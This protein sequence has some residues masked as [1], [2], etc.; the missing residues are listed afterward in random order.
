MTAGPVPRLLLVEDSDTQALQFRRSIE[1]QGFSV[2][3]TRTAEEAL[4]QLNENLPDLLVVDYR[5]PGMNGDELVRIV[6][7]T[8]RTRTLP[9]LMLTGDAGSETERQ[10]LDSGA[11]A[12]VPKGG[13]ADL[14][15]SRMR[16]LL[17]Q[18]RPAPDRAAGEGG[19]RAAQLLLVEPA[20]TYRTLLRG[21]LA[22]E[23]YEARLAKD[24]GEALAALDSGD[25]D[26]VLL[27][28]DSGGGLDFV[29]R[30]DAR[31]TASGEGYEIVLLSE[32]DGPEAV[33]AAL[34]AGADDVVPKSSNREMLLVRIRATVRR[35]LARDDEARAAAHE[36]ERELALAHARAQAEAAEA[37]AAA[38][39][40]LADAN[41]RLQATQAQ[42]VQAAKMASLGELVAGIA[43]E[44]NN[45]LA[46]ILA[47][48]DT[49]ERSVREA[50]TLEGE[51][52]A[53][54]LAKAADR[55]ASIRTGLARIQD[56][57]VKLRR[58]SRLDEET[59]Q[60]DVPEAIEAVLTL[61]GPKLGGIAVE[62]RYEAPPTLTCSPALINQVVMNLVS[63]AADAV[64]EPDGRIVVATRCDGDAYVIEVG[65]NGRGVAAEHRE[66]V[67]EPF[68]TTKDVGAGTGL[69]LAI[70][71]G[72]V[73]AHGGGIVLGES[74]EGGALFTISIP[75]R[76]A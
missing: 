35:K 48:H 65:D 46:F 73:R 54:R 12:Y 51:A 75:I 74:P 58:F 11:N 76:P 24:E 30:L 15:V 72:I 47:H 36:R 66:R 25:V 41:A 18:R 2:A 1:P 7:Q 49:V 21:L 29:G 45:P 28:L 71:Y 42:L 70:A 64:D 63:N 43:H 50:R 40:E 9:I 27:G 6:R 22:G 56:L 4:E 38:N 52:Q 67:F 34:A 31:R 68:F 37:L 53:A 26:C 32:E 16:A 59:A 8:G 5:L 10:G 17:R 61:L 69:G 55:L 19:L 3:R 33:L 20:A 13:G 14:L 44:I 23:G 62:R 57:V 60:L 39:R